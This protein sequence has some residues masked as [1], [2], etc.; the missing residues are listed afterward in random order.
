M[1]PHAEV[2]GQGTHIGHDTVDSQGLWLTAPAKCHVGGSDL[3]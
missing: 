1:C 2:P 3:H